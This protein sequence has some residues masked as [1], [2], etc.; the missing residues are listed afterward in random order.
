MPKIMADHDVEGH[1]Q[2]LLNIWSSPQWNDIWADAAC[3]VETFERLGIGPDATD[4][5]I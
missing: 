5:E 4:S 3:E 1:L 2:V